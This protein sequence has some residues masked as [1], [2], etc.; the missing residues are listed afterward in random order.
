MHLYLE[1]DDNMRWIYDP[2]HPEYN[3]DHAKWLRERRS[4]A[5]TIAPEWMKREAQLN[6]AMR[7]AKGGRDDRVK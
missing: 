5:I 6:D 7:R 3:S 1:R 2:S 4:M